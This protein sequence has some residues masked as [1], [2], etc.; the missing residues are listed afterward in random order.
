MDEVVAC[1]R[2]LLGFWAELHVCRFTFKHLSEPLRSH[3]LSF[4]TLET[5]LKIL[6]FVHPNIAKCV[7]LWNPHIFFHS[8]S[9]TSLVCFC[10]ETP[11]ICIGTQSPCI[12]N[13]S[14]CPKFCLHTNPICPNNMIYNWL[15]YTTQYL[16]PKNMFFGHLFGHFFANFPP[17]SKYDVHD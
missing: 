13:Q 16:C 3:I 10:T 4:R 8:N 14:V 12:G 15:Y 11:S 17:F 9:A 5:L 7:F 6:P 1:S 2:R